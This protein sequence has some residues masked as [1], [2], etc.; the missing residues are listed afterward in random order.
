[1]LAPGTRTNMGSQ[2]DKMA[3][4]PSSHFSVAAGLLQLGA[5]ST[6]HLCREDIGCLL[7]A[8]R[9]AQPSTLKPATNVSGAHQVARFEPPQMRHISFDSS[10]A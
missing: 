4:N 6:T 3:N 7:S 9:A 1:M 10:L 8:R 5:E 2:I